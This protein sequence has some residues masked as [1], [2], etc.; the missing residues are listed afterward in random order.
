M[1]VNQMENNCSK[2]VITLI[3]IIL[4]FSLIENAQ[5][6][7]WSERI[8]F[9]KKFNS[10][11]S[12]FCPYY[13]FLS[14]FGFFIL[15]FSLRFK[16]TFFT[17]VTLTLGYTSIWYKDKNFLGHIQFFETIGDAFRTD[18]ACLLPNHFTYW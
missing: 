11:I 4:K 7:A 10:K 15:G 14:F 13:N 6:Q 1:K 3:R 18:C 2:T 8:K 16:Q 5:Y 12:C 9:R 17:E